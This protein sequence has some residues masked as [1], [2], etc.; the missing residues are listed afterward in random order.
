MLWVTAQ[1]GSSSHPTHVFA[2]GMH[3]IILASMFT[4]I[5]KVNIVSHTSASRARSAAPGV[6]ASHCWQIMKRAQHDHE[7]IHTGESVQFSPH[8]LPDQPPPSQHPAH[9]QTQK[10]S[11]NYTWS[12]HSAESFGMDQKTSEWVLKNNT[13]GVHYISIFKAIN[14]FQGTFCTYML[15]K[16]MGSWKPG[17]QCVAESCT[18]HHSWD[19]TTVLKQAIFFPPA[20]CLCV[21]MC[22]WNAEWA[23]YISLPYLC[24]LPF[25]SPWHLDNKGHIWKSKSA[26][27]PMLIYSYIYKSK[28]EFVKTAEYLPPAENHMLNM[29]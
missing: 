20:P 21:C 27:T 25:Q 15:I 1:N 12:S 3:I 22:V 9:T 6:R 10:P 28:G 14:N 13:K 4:V 2:N 24:G 29:T 8:T 7:W 17:F 26:Q 23:D 18:R 16:A 19:M 5:L 11:P